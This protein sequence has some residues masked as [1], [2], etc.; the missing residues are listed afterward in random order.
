MKRAKAEKE[1]NLLEK[2]ENE[3][4]LEKK[5]KPRSKWAFLG[6]FFIYL[7]VVLVLV[8]L[9]F[10]YKVILS[11]NSVI[12]SSDIPSLLGQLK[13]FVV[14]PDDLIDGE[15]EDRVNVLLLGMGGAGHSGGYLADTIMIASVK[16]STQE[17]AFI[18]IPRDLY[19]PIP[20]H[21]WRKINNAYAFGYAEDTKG[22]GEK[23]ITEVV[24][25]ITGLTIHYYGRADFEGF[26]KVIDDLGGV[27][28]YVD[29]TFYDPLYPDYNY[30]YQPVSFQEGNNH[31]NGE[32]ALQFARSRHGNNNEGSDF[33]RSQRQQKILLALKDKLLSSYTLLN[34]S[35]I[36]NIVGDLAD[37][38][39]TNM[40]PWE[41]IKLY[42]MIKDVTVDQIIDEVIDNSPDGPLHS[43]TTID[44]AYILRPNAGL[45]DFSD[46]QDIAQN[47]F[48]AEET[49]TVKRENATIEIHN[50][51]KINGLA[52]KT[53][54]TLRTAGYNVVAI[55]NA[56]EQNN[57]TTTI[58]DLTGG[59]KP[60]TLETLKL[61]IGSETASTVPAY[62][63]T[64]D[65]NE[66]TYQG[67]SAPL[68]SEIVSQSGKVDF[69]I[70]LGTN[71]T[72]QTNTS[73]TNT[74]SQ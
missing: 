25:N 60:Q 65:K 67:L 50:G 44:G 70:L 74:Q 16:P 14:A 31:F 73:I 56:A 24:E 68:N 15:K 36:L 43:E 28:I 51:T 52:A 23:L 12:A 72:T 66:V 32:K 49:K 10:S 26:R 69:L 9:T 35:L 1:V 7:S 2:V 27:N 20:G 58:Y 6:K 38:V 29:R 34:P 39:R 54:E 42:N 37:H 59:T 61:E 13:Y 8:G 17:V 53:A 46:I 62:L 71:E 64:P 21:E 63:Y 55:G 33:A 48:S 3:Q 4:A 40:E 30:G 41:M 11:A 18:S 22:G 19:V 5:K 57:E 45:D 47:I